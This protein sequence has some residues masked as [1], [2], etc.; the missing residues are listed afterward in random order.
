MKNKLL[1][2]TSPHL[3]DPV[4]TSNIMLTVVVALVPTAIA[5]TL[6]FGLRAL[7]LIC[8]CVAS[9]II[10][11]YLY[12]VVTRQPNTISDCSAVVT[13]MLLAFNLPSTFPFWM[14]MVGC[15]VAI[16]VMKM[17]FGGI[18]KNFANPAIGARVV[19]LVSFASAMGDASAFVTLVF[20]DGAISHMAGATPLAAINTTQVSGLGE[21]GNMALGSVEGVPNVFEL[22]F[23]LRGGCLGETCIITLLIG[24]CYLIYKKV[25]SP[26]IPLTYIGTVFVLSWILGVN[27]V[28]QVLAGG[29][30]LG[31]FF[32]ATDY[33]TSPVTK[34]GK[35]IFAVGCGLLTVVI[36]LYGQYVEGVSF[37]ILLMNILT[38]LIDRWTK[39]KPFGGLAK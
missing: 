20:S 21:I 10:F 33:S 2:V 24:G 25:I 39:T 13:G 8:V 1:V 31:A 29:L 23:G 28:S 4:T 6:L 37:A 16:V 11:E 32:M 17:L 22:L 5:A 7:M 14:A 34:K 12:N 36:R 38:P 35:A 15:F 9:C 18:G 3:K 19:L 27:P 30:V 26:I